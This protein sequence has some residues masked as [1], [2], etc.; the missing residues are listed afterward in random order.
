MPTEKPLYVKKEE[1]FQKK[2]KSE[3]ELHKERLKQIRDF[4]QPMDFKEI[5]SHEKK[6]EIQRKR[7]SYDLH[8][9]R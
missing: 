8:E 6:F 7:L 3:L 9:K 4:F 1:M 2:K 5:S